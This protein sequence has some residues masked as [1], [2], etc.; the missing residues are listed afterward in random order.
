MTYVIGATHDSVADVTKRYTRKF[1]S[2]EFQ[3]RRREFGPDENASD[4]AFLQMNTTLKQMT[5]IPKGR[6]ED[7]EKRAKAEETFF[8]LVQSSGVWDSDYK[9]GRI[10]GSWA[11]K[12]AR[13]ELG[14]HEKKKDDNNTR[15]DK[16]AKEKVQEASFLVESFYPAPHHQN[17]LT[18]RVQH[19][20]ISS[21][22][23][24]SH[25]D[26]IVV[27]GV[28][29]ASTLSS[30]ISIVV[31][32]ELSG[33]I[34]QSR[35]F[36]SWLSVGIFIDTLPSGRIVAICSNVENCTVDETTST[37]L[38]RVGGLSVESKVSP[39][40]LLFVGQI[41]FHPK[42][43]TAI[44]SCDESKVVEVT[45]QLN[46]SP[47]LQL[48]LR[49]ETNTAPA[50]ISTRLPEYIMPLKTQMAAT[51][52]QKRVAFEAFMKQ[53]SKSN[54]TADVVGYV[55]YVPRFFFSSCLK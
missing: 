37:Q 24:R 13:S 5:N 10:S 19:P 17:N 15:N 2:D 35:A 55:S 54:S 4:R 27:N 39:A 36:F 11:W 23:E 20:S 44:H 42:W 7:L 26:C 30:G 38:Q 29:C 3:T 48:K 50:T 6:M 12:A 32:D 45:I 51:E 21:P 40:S 31:V 1:F 9:E 53:S 14:D 41:G 52:Y 47:S 34:L 25:H 49:T 46:I 8:G 18:I 28:R 43:A 22:Q 33:C 16:D